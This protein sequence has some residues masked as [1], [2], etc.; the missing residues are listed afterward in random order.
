MATY[1]FDIRTKPISTQHLHTYEAVEAGSNYIFPL[2]GG[3][4]GNL[5]GSYPEIEVHLDKYHGVTVKLQYSPRL[6]DELDCDYG[7]SVFTWTF[8]RAPHTIIVRDIGR[9]LF[10][11]SANLGSN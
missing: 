5:L 7:N 3:G 1:E 6:G 2:T 11:M 9:P 4:Q 8:K 10:M